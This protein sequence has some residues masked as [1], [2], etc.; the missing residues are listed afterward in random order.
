MKPFQVILL[1]VFGL[2]ALLG[3]GLFA[4][5]SGGGG[6][7]DAVGP[8]TIW[9][10]LP[11]D[12]MT[13][14]LA[15]IATLDKRFAEALYEE[16]DAGSFGTELATAIAEG[17]SPDLLLISQEQLMNERAKLSLIPSSVLS[18]REFL[19]RYLPISEAFLTAGGTFGVP[20]LVDP[21]V[22]YYN[23]PMI[24]GAGL[25]SA[26]S[27]WEAVSAL[28]QVL[29]NRTDAGT[30]SR[31]VI[32]FGEYANVTNARGIL[33]L[34]LLQAGTP[35]VTQNELGYEA[36]LTGSYAASASSALEF[37]TQ[38]A[39]PAKTVY[40]WNR[41]LPSSRSAFLAGD[42][43]LYP[44][45][46][47]ERAFLSAANPNLDF[48]MAR[49]PQPSVAENRTT[50]ALAYAFAIPR[51]SLNPAGAMSAAFGLSA[52]GT[53]AAARFSM[54]PASR[55][56][57]GSAGDDRYAAVYYTEALIARG[58]A[59]PAPSIVDGIF[60]GMIS[61]ITSGRRDVTDALRSAAD[62]LNDSIQ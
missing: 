37:F 32:P 7:T 22:M 24:A 48:D 46:A 40:T 8:V 38:F 41:N 43:A 9:G 23:R 55:G 16:H 28:T 45:F 15:E 30:V 60:A 62:S 25:V 20:F 26:P 58:W 51:A 13:D 53:L 33:S 29:T 56:L 52:N 44:G 61:N 54:V 3:L 47:S 59:S 31:S 39:N 1:S 12:T 14:F 36:A 17:Q 4:T 57:L 35:I 42:L 19:D 21:M 27:S 34:L 11:Q 50:Y 10:T 2:A 5:F 49:I 6:G 18:E